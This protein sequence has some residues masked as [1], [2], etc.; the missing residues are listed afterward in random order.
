M[1]VKVRAGWL[2][3]VEVRLRIGQVQQ[4]KVR[5]AELLELKLRPGSV[6]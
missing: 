1:E 2:L 6:L 3:Q 4:V 5:T